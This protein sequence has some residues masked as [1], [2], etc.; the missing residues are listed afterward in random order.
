MTAPWSDGRRFVTVQELA[1]YIGLP[2]RTL[3]DHI[4]KGALPARRMG[5]RRLLITARDA[6]VYVGEPPPAAPD[7]SAMS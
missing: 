4:R 7:A 2:E 3:R 6:S 5:P 1:A